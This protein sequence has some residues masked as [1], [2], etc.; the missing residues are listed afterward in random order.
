MPF[1]R[2]RIPVG[3]FKTESPT[4]INSIHQ[5]TVIKTHTPCDFLYLLSMKHFCVF[6][7]LTH[8]GF[9]EQRKQFLIDFFFLI[10]SSW[11]LTRKLGKWIVKVWEV[12]HTPGCDMV[13]TANTQPFVPDSERNAEQCLTPVPPLFSLTELTSFLFCRNIS[14]KEEVVVTQG[15]A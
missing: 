10:T 6:Y 15:F 12:R 1:G 9:V 14:S 2:K 11:F 7:N 3:T 5:F 13:L 8:M 4:V